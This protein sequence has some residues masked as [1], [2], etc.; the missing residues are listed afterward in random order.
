M[1]AVEPAAAPANEIDALLHEI[2]LCGE[3]YQRVADSRAV[4]SKA[5]VD[6]LITFEDVS[7]DILKHGN[8][9]SLDFFMKAK[10]F[11][12]EALSMNIEAL[13]AS[14]H[15]Q[16]EIHASRQAQVE[17]DFDLRSKGHAELY[18]NVIDE[19]GQS[20]ER[21]HKNRGAFR[22]DLGDE[23]VLTNIVSDDEEEEEEEEGEALNMGSISRCID[24]DFFWNDI[25]AMETEVTTLV[26]Y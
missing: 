5:T 22:D 26:S 15:T 1:S 4:L 11:W 10:N 25:V 9:D 7:Q 3:V 24:D 18:M 2:N 21:L 17:F 8:V 13:P 12:D 20:M 23:H 6:D 19:C 16:N 14:T